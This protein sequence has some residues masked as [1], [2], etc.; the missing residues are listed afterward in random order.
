MNTFHDYH[1]KG[2]TTISTS[3]DWVNINT[4]GGRN[5]ILS[6][7]IKKKNDSDKDIVEELEK[8]AEEQEADRVNNLPKFN[9][10]ELDI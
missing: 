5:N 7:T 8:I 2:Y 6:P 3:S 1:L 9:P 4:S 10:E